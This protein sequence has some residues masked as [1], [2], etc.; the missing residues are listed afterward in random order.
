MPHKHH[1]LTMKNIASATAEVNNYGFK[2]Q[3]KPTPTNLK[4]D[5]SE[6]KGKLSQ[7]AVEDG[8]Y[9]AESGDMAGER[10]KKDYNNNAPVRWNPK[11]DFVE[12]TSGFT[13]Q[14]GAF[15]GGRE[16][17][18][19]GKK[20]EYAVTQRKPSSKKNNDPNPHPIRFR[21]KIVRFD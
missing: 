18:K 3:S 4:Y 12:E 6:R 2:R 8:V 20:S 1:R 10:S 7:R 17:T 16:K 5:P 9:L 19:A 15:M 13:E 11:E 14:S 21:K